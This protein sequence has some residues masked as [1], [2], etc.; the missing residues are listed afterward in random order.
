MGGWRLEVKADRKGVV[1]FE[2]IF[3]STGRKRCFVLRG[4]LGMQ[5][6]YVYKD[7]PSARVT[8]RD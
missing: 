4:G 6:D 5:S 7:P 3:L 1:G 8:F 2:D